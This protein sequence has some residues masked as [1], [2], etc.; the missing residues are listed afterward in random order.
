MWNYWQLTNR[1]MA[2]AQ[3]KFH[4]ASDLA[5]VAEPIRCVTHK[6]VKFTW[7]NEQQIAF[8]KVKLL[9]A[10]SE[11]LAHYDPD[12]KTTVIA[13]ASSYG[14]GAVLL[15]KGRHG[16][17]VVAYGHRSLSQVERRYSQTEREAL[18]LVFGCEQF[19]LY[20]LGDEF[21]LVTNH[22]PLKSILNRPDSKPTSRVECWAL[23][24]QCFKFEVVYKKGISNVADPLSRF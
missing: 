21:D 5:T 10:R 18:A 20:L 3:R 12:A 16:E 19:M 23:R 15:Q 13:D 8:E 24:L 1:F 17:R 6:A 14:L 7:G 11:T 9:M 22:K 4:G 2:M